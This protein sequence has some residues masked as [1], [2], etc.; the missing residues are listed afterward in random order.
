[1]LH[2]LQHFYKI[3]IQ[4]STTQC[5]ALGSDGKVVEI[6]ICIIGSY[7][8]LTLLSICSGIIIEQVGISIMGRQLILILQLTSNDTH[9]YCIVSCC[10]SNT[11]LTVIGI[12][13]YC[14]LFLIQILSD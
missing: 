14:M 8:F 12:V 10:I 1:M 13:L 3:F 6:S 5:D 7:F 9:F 4:F 11:N 2:V